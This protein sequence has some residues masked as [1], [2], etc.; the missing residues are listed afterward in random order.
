[1]NENDL[2]PHLPPQMFF[3]H[4]GNRMLLLDNAEP[5]QS[6]DTWKGF[7]REA[8]S[9]MGELAEETRNLFNIADPHKL[10]SEGGYLNRLAATLGE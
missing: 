4:A 8:W 3:S 9:W 7:I 10:D 6:E 5:N 1:M 2:V